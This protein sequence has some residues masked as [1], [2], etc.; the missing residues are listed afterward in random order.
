MSFYN[1][2]AIDISGYQLVQ[3]NATLTYSIPSSTLI[4]SHATSS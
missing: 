2:D 3:A 1:D 4:P